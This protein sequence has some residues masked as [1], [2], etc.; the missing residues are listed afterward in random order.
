MRKTVWVDATLDFEFEGHFRAE[1]V[2]YGQ[3]LISCDLA[4]FSATYINLYSV[5]NLVLSSQ[6]AQFG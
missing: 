6:N 3:K 2:K 5:P 4:V 1:K